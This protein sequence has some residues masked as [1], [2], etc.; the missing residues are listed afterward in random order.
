MKPFLRPA[1]YKGARGGRGSGKSWAFAEMM[2]EAHV[3]DPDT[4]SVCIREIQNTLSESVK[5]LLEQTITRMGVSSYFDIQESVIKSR[6]GKGRIIF[7]GMQNHT[8]DSIKSLEGY[9]RAWVEEAQSLS[10]RSLDLLRPT[11]RAEGSELWFT[12]NPVNPDDP[13]DQLLCSG[14]PPSNS[15]VVD[16]N[17]VDN[18]W[19]TETL[20]AEME[21]D[22]ATADPGKFAHVWYG[23]Y[24]TRTE[25]LVYTNWRTEEFSAPKD[26]EFRFGADWGFGRDPTVLVRCYIDG[27]RLYVDYEAYQLAC[28]TRDLSA[29][30]ATVPDSHLWPIVAD[31]ARPEN[32]D[33]VKKHGFP[34][35][36]PSI[37]GAESVEQGVDWLQ[38]FEIVVHPR[39]VHT[40]RELGS[41]S[42]KIDKKRDVVLPVLADKDNH[43]MDALRYACESARRTK[44]VARKPPKMI[45]SESRW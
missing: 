12:W 22:R 24:W 33:E 31:S 4:S 11:I 17:F 32:I 34:K 39:C 14:E 19:F 3:N 20:R 2:I 44:T 27:R 40:I 10:Q 42:Y 29:L 25:S 21:H 36:I 1:R 38:G 9:D 18:P 35:T 26:A 28:P 43:V 15:V 5:K 6:H 23:A 45:P 41:Y 37:K 30:F 7:L 13:I 8:A 16:V